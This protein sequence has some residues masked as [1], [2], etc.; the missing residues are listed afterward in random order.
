MKNKTKTYKQG[1]SKIRVGAIILLTTPITTIIIH[2]VKTTP[3]IQAIT[4][5]IPEIIAAAIWTIAAV[6]LAKYSEKLK[7]GL[8]G[9]AILTAT[10]ITQTITTPILIQSIQQK[11]T[12]IAKIA[13]ITLLA[14]TPLLLIAP[15]LAA[16]ALIRLEELGA[17]KTF[18]TAGTTIIAST[19]IMAALTPLAFAGPQGQ[20]TLIT[21]LT[22][23]QIIVGI[24]LIKASNKELKTLEKKKHI[25]T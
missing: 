22:I 23:I 7:I 15:I 1:I 10:L 6:K 4:Q 9:T 11:Q 19:L 20:A 16:I 2:A 12:Q 25:L 17:N 18:K 8:I 13:T 14:T 5:P 3:I 21:I 24:L